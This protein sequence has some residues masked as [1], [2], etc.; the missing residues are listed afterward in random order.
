[1]QPGKPADRPAEPRPSL[2][3]RRAN[4][5]GYP[6]VWG[7]QAQA[8]TLFSSFLAVVLGVVFLPI[9]TLSLWI[10]LATAAHLIGVT[11]GRGW[12]LQIALALGFLA[13]C[14]VAYLILDRTSMLGSRRARAL[15]LDKAS[16]LLGETPPRRFFVQLKPGRPL[17]TPDED[18]GWLFLEA[19]RLEF[20]GDALRLT[21][22][23]ALAARVT[24][25]PRLAALGLGGPW[26]TLALHLPE[27][28]EARLRFLSRDAER[29]SATTEG[30]RELETALRRWLSAS[31]PV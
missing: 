11:E 17:V 1:M 6:R 27:E 24:T 23:R 10:P 29:L 31:L 14:G 30:A 3:V 15:L 12:P 2:T 22:P 16:Q 25:G 21:L 26:L 20:V 19:D 28:G 18:I 7:W 4:L 13:A 9:A 5:A 8:A